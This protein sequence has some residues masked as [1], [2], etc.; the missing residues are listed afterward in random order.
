MYISQVSGERLQDHWSSG[1]YFCSKTLIVGT[2][3]ND[4][5]IYVLSENKKNIKIFLMKIFNY[6]NLR[7]IY[8]LH[9]HVFV[10]GKMS[11]IFKYRKVEWN[12]IFIILITVI[13]R[14]TDN[15]SACC[16]R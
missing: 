14:V 13:S 6:Y 8:L 4:P 5:T 1:S 10:M 2:H 3:Y 12:L 15:S 9:G 7:K 16:L 11:R